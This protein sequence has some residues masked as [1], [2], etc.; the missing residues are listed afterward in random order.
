MRANDLLKICFILLLAVVFIRCKQ[1]TDS[2]GSGVIN[3]DEPSARIGF[4]VIEIQ[5]PSSMRAWVSSDISRT[6]FEVLQ[7]P[8]GWV[9]N[10][11]RES[12]V[13]GG[14]FLKSPD[15]DS[16]GEFLDETFFGYNWRHTATVIQANIA[17]DGQGLLN[18][19]RVHKYHVISY[20]A[21]R[22][23]T[24]LIS[25]EDKVYVRIGRDADRVNDDPS[26]PDVWRLSEY[27]TPEK[28]EFQLPEETLVIRTD[29]QDSF[30]GPVQELEGVI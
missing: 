14:H 3:N 7:L 1:G 20:D 5:S 24:V 10:Q 23:I 13:D 22:T 29:N 2:N 8:I 19:S 26:I 21:G 28:L 12:D 6:E 30:Q 27:I 4:E 16:E 15:T 11:P 17:L 9:K 25:P 18:G